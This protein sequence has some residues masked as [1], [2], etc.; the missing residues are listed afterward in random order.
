MKLIVS[1]VILIVAA[2]ILMR[3]IHKQIRAQGKILAEKREN[4]LKKA[5]EKHKDCN[6]CAASCPAVDRYNC[7]RSPAR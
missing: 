5:A 2:G 4:Q 1:V 6:K 3:P 7:H